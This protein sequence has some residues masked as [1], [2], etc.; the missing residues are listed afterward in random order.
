MAGTFLSES[1]NPVEDVQ[2]VSVLK[3]LPSYYDNLVGVDSE[4]QNHTSYVA[5][6]FH[7]SQSKQNVPRLPLDGLMKEK[8][9][10][11]EKYLKSGNVSPVT[12]TNSRRFLVPE[13]DFEKYSRVPK[14]DQVTQP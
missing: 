2:W 3:Q 5:S 9:D 14:V 11:I 1:R 12:T 8:W 10:S 13:E 7:K 6:T 4:V